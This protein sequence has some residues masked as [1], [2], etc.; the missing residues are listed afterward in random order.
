M[1]PNATWQLSLNKSHLET[2]GVHYE[3]IK[4]KNHRKKIEEGSKQKKK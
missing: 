1:K 3:M 2:T 4:D